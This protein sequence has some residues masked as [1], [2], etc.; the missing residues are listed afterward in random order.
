ME[1]LNQI[2]EFDTKTDNFN[3]TNFQIVVRGD[4]AK[5][6]KLVKS[7]KW[8]ALQ[9]EINKASEFVATLPE[10][11]SLTE[12]MADAEAQQAENAKTSTKIKN[13]FSKK[14][15]KAEEQK[16]LQTQEALKKM[17]EEAQEDNI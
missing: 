9:D 1:E 12:T 8:L 7:F 14:D 15:K 11:D 3:A 5:P 10:P 13:A 17:Q 16:K 2:P 6:L 4:V